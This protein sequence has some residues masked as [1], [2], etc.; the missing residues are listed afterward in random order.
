MP[1]KRFFTGSELIYLAIILMYCRYCLSSYRV[2]Y[3]PLTDMFPDN[4]CRYNLALK[5]SEITD[6]PFFFTA[7]IYKVIILLTVL[8]TKWEQLY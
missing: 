3:A 5:V 4:I 1:V 2:S 6:Y 7:I 8:S